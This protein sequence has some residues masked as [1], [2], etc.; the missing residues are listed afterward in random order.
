[1]LTFT[2]AVHTD[3]DVNLYI[4][5]HIHSWLAN[6]DFALVE[7]HELQFGNLISTSN[8]IEYGDGDEEVEVQVVVHDGYLVWTMEM[9]LFSQK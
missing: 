5:I 8:L 6:A 1:M 4:R 9:T 3:I 7:K 2:F